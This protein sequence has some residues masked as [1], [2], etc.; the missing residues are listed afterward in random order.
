MVM[1]RRFA[2]VNTFGL[3]SRWSDGYTSMLMVGSPS[4]ATKRFGLIAMAMTAE[5]KTRSVLRC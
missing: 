2:S 4:V 1:K 5:L 3:A